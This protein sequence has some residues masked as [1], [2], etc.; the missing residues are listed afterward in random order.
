ML[1]TL[2]I[3]LPCPHDMYRADLVFEG[4]FDQEI[5]V[6]LEDMKLLQHHLTKAE[7]ARREGTFPC[8]FWIARIV[9]ITW[10]L[11]TTGD[12]RTVFSSYHSLA[13]Y[14]QGIRDHKTTIY[15]YEKALE[16]AKLTQDKDAE[17]DATHHLGLAYE[18]KGDLERSIRF[19]EKHLSLAQDHSDSPQILAAHKQLVSHAMN[20]S[21]LLFQQH[22]GFLQTITYE[23]RAAA[24]EQEQKYE[25]AIVLYLK[26][27]HAA[28]SCNDKSAEAQANYKAGRA[29][30]LLE[31]P[32]KAISYL[33]NYVRVCYL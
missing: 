3:T 13:Q 31:Q 21:H 12:T 11:P 24:L 17:M 26:A 2:Y 25:Q 28:K 32:E 30:V 14:Y 5:D 22:W 10:Y 6:P 7:M 8:V 16:I 33:Q 4:K 1:I 23:A 15:F 18:V 29:H 19:H 9:D 27:M 20:L